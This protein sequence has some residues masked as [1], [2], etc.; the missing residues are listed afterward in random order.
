MVARSKAARSG[1]LGVASALVGI[2]VPAAWVWTTVTP[3]EDLVQLRN[4]IGAE[5]G[6]MPDFTWGPDN[7]PT[8][9][10]LNE[11]AVP[12]A[13]EQLAAFAVPGPGQPTGGEFESALAISRDLMK[14]PKRVGGP[15]REDSAGTY[16]E[17]TERG[18][19]YCADFTKVFNGMAIAAKVPVRQ[20]GFAFNGF[21]SGHTFNEIYDSRRG[22]W[23]MV[24]SFHSLFFVDAGSR[25]PLS[26]LEVHD[27]LLGLADDAGPV[28]IER[29]VPDR[30]P[31]RSDNLAID[32]YRRGM[33]QLWLV[34]GSNIFDYEASWPGQLGYRFHRAAGQLVGIFL[35]TYPT[36]RI[37]PDGLSR[38]DLD[39]LTEGR[40]EFLMAVTALVIALAVFGLALVRMIMRGGRQDIHDV[41]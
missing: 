15:V 18:R 20:W 23:L 26:V 32:Y 21:G 25:E 9:Y 3:G 39:Q 14:A 11:G 13:F 27:R 4:S 2:L 5:V 37:Y 35:G 19:G 17:I 31:F 7:P 33:S 30:Y 28:A 24:D 12:P 40:N 8:T 1:R 22:K 16:A 34:W 6:Q 41:R 29:I 10:L 36:I 38:R